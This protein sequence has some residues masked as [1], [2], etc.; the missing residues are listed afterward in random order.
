MCNPQLF[1]NAFQGAKMKGAEK[2]KKA[3]KWGW[4]DSSSQRAASRPVLRSRLRTAFAGWQKHRCSLR[5]QHESQTVG[6][7]APR[8]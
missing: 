5:F 7:L 8:Q 3:S 2:D 6:F 4:L 1:E